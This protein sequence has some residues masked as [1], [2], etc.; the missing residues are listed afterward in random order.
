M[1]RIERKYYPNGTLQE[2][3]HFRN[4][5]EH[6]LW[7]RWHPNGVLAAEWLFEDGLYTTF[8]S[9]TWDEHGTLRSEVPFVN[10]IQ[11]GRHSAYD[12][13]SN[14]LARQYVL[15]TGTVSRATYD[16]ACETRPELHRYE[17][18]PPTQKRPRTRSY[19]TKSESKLDGSRS[20][21]AAARSE[22]ELERDLAFVNIR[23]ATTREDAL[24]WIRN[25]TDAPTR[26]L[27][28]MATEESI[29]FINTLYELGTECVYVTDLESLDNADHSAKHLLVRLPATANQRRRIFEFANGFI[30]DRGFDEEADNGQTFLY[31]Y[32]G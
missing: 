26:S 16:A 22:S 32:V 21:G 7:R 2:E 11:I 29:V 15:E 27:G 13:K 25:N 23:L 3:I 17:P 1:D 12:E 5:K 28:E 4:N 14:I 19:R 20:A 9:K 10:G 6:G 24:S 31:I 8:I 18:D 30:S